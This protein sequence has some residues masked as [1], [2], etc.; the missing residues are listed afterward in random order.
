[1]AGLDSKD[2]SSWLVGVFYGHCEISVKKS[3]LAQQLPP[4]HYLCLCSKVSVQYSTVQYSTVQYST[5]QYS[6]V[7]LLHPAIIC[8]YVATGP[9]S[10]PLPGQHNL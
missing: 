9:C 10:R 1:M 5:V 6:T 7:Q 4:S 2:A 8:V 3:S